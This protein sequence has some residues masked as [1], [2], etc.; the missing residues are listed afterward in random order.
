MSYRFTD[1][2][3]AGSELQF[4]PDPV[5]LVSFI[6]RMYGHMNVKKNASLYAGIMMTNDI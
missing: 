3:R 6:V 5:H 1:S 4:H 2:L